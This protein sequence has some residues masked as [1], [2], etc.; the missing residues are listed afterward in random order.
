MD[1][2][3]LQWSKNE[4]HYDEDVLEGLQP[5]SN[6]RKLKIEGF[7]GKSL[8]LWM[9]KSRDRLHH[10]SSEAFVMEGFSS[11]QQLHI[12]NCKELTY[13]TF[14]FLSLESLFIENCPKLEKFLDSRFL[15]LQELVIVNLGVE[16][17]DG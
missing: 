3:I 14:V 10:N 7:G 11:L 16:N 4:T 2:L 9:L 13:A 1:E 15:L 6:L 17:I 12:D 8:P 5:H